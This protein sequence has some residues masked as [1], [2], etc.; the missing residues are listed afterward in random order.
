MNNNVHLQMK[1]TCV[2]FSLKATIALQNDCAKWILGGWWQKRHWLCPLNSAKRRL[3]TWTAFTGHFG[4]GQ[5]CRAT[6][7]WCRPEQIY[8]QGPFPVSPRLCFF[9]CGTCIFNSN[10]AIGLQW[11]YRNTTDSSVSAVC[12]L[13]CSVLHVCLSL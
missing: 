1:Y 4:L 2:W 12:L 9:H 7:R 3:H 13:L 8:I 6:M 5:P 11:K 10:K